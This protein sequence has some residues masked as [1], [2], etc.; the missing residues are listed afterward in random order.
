MTTKDIIIRAACISLDDYNTHVFNQAAAYLDGIIGTDEHAKSRLM[1]SP[2]FW[3]WWQRQWDNREERFVLVHDLDKL[4]GDP[5]LIELIA[6]LW[7]DLHSIESLN[8][9]PNR[10]VLESSYAVMIGEVFD[11]AK[12]GGDHE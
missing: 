2:H 12:S 3:S 11:H 4:V 7:Y 10:M 8:I 5:D 1:Q 9:R 6:E